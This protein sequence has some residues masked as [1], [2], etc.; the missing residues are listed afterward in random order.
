MAGPS[1]IPISSGEIVPGGSG[2]EIQYEGLDFPQRS[3]L[4]FNGVSIEITDNA[5]DDTTDVWVVIEP[6]VIESGEATPGQI[7][8]ATIDGFAAWEDIEFVLDDELDAIAAVASTGVLVRTGAAAWT[9][10][11]NVENTALSTWAGTSNITTLGTIVTGVWN[12]TAITSAY[13]GDLSS[14]YQVIDAG[15]TSLLGTDT[16]ADLFPYTTN[17]SVWASASITAAGRAS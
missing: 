8:V 1:K 5:I 12:G 16:G 13:I 4:N 6:S 9:T 2:H 14:I 11:S 17:T 10:Y 15:L 7:L 3:I